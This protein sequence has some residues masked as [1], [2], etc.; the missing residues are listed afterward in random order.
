MKSY[1]KKC[2]ISAKAAKKAAFRTRLSMKYNLIFVDDIYDCDFILVPVTENKVTVEQT[3]DLDIAKSIGL[4]AVSLSEEKL[5]TDEDPLE[6]NIEREKM[7]DE[8]DY[9]LE[10]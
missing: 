10:L 6:L 4:D 8:L 7:N 3:T 9:G 2:F 5:L 1:Q